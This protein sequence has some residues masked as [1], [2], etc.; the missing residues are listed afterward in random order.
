MY[1]FPEAVRL[2]CHPVF[3]RRLAMVQIQECTGRAPDGLHESIVP[4][5]HD[6]STDGPECW[7]LVTSGLFQPQVMTRNPF[8][9]NKTAVG[10][11][12]S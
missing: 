6:V 4:V 9:A 5:P 3:T 2:P 1:Q 11:A 8:M 10:S 12:L 7:A